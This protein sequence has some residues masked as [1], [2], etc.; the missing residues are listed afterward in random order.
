MDDHTFQQFIKEQVEKWKRLQADKERDT[1]QITV[2]TVSSEPGSGGQ[3]VAREV[4]R[5][6]EFDLFEREI[7][8][9]IAQSVQISAAV[10]DTIEKDRLTGVEDFL[11]SLVNDKYLWPGLYLQHLMKV[12]GV[13]GKH[14]RA[15]I[16]GRGANFIIPPAEALKLRIVAPLEIRIRNIAQA[17]DVSLPEAKKRVVN[18]ESKRR[19]FIRQ[20]FNANIADAHHYDLVINTCQLPIDRAVEIVCRA[21]D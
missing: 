7:V 9:K 19:A 6:L 18:R 11:A 12:I 13:I 5:K 4:A 14:G 21:L 2:V 16:V 3:I 10:I 1:R 17:F 8:K 15:V 20:S